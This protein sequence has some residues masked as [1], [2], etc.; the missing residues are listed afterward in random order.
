M[1]TFEFETR[2]SRNLD[3]RIVLSGLQW[4][5]T[6]VSWP[7]ILLKLCART[8]QCYHGIAV[9]FVFFFI[10]LEELRFQ[11]MKND[12]VNISVS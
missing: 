11:G 4:L 9:D 3:V 12:H 6:S 8:V 2:H 7:L 10:V 5:Q 1:A